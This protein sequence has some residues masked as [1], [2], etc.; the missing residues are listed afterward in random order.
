ME[1]LTGTLENNF[2]GKNFVF[3][4]RLGERISD[5][6][7]SN[8]HQCGEPSD[9]HVNCKNKTCNL[10]FIQCAKCAEAHSGCCS[11]DCLVYS[12]LPEEEQVAKRKGEKSESRFHNHQKRDL[13][14][15]FK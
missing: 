12:R 8:C 7:I 2:K 1:D 5:K 9:E 14:K 11:P 4:E 13:S 15:G 6:I 3:D 10:L